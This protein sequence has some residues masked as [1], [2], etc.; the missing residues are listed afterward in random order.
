LSATDDRAGSARSLEPVLREVVEALAA[1]ERG[2]GSP[3]EAEAARWLAARLEQAGCEVAVEDA[4]YH[5]GYA[6]VIAPL[7]ATGLVGGLLTLFGGRRGRRLGGLLGLGSAALI[8]DDAANMARVFRRRRAPRPTQNVVASCGDPAARRTL[9][10]L[11]HHDAAPTGMIFD[12]RL[13]TRFGEMF[14][15]VLERI[16]T[17]LPLWWGVLA[18]PAAVALGARREHRRG[19]RW[20]GTSLSA[21]TTAIF[22]DIERSPIVPGA[23]D[24]AT[25]LAVQVAL[26]A[27]LAAE[28]VQG[29]RVLLVSCGAEEVVQGGIYSFAERHFPSLDREHTWFLNLETLGS[30]KLVLLEGEGTVL[31]EDYFDRGFRDLVARVADRAGAP[32]R[33]G[34]RARNSTDSVVPSR[35][36]YPTATLASMDRYKALSNYHTMDDTAANVDYRTVAHALL[37]TEEVA[38]ELAANPWLGGS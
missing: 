22:L 20:L 1:I 33:R 38:R 29:L 9:V 10:V 4:E 36:G 3:G 7:A 17:S 25:A 2:P 34:M 6:N 37:V 30:P 31:M 27:R 5:D 21:L 15:G 12:D 26:A 28:P 8:A 23:N 11:G 16:D 19:L 32:L 18:G 13:Q 14:P 35:A 24:N